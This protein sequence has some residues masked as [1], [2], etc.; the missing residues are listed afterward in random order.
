[1]NAPALIALL[2]IVAASACER[3]ERRFQELA[4]HADADGEGP[5]DDVA[6]G[7][8]EG[9]R[10][11]VWF[12]CAGCHANGGG[13]MGP[14]LMDDVWRYGSSPQAVYASIVEGRPNGMPSFGGKIPETE[15]W[16]LVAYVR[17]LSGLTRNDVVPGR[18][19]HLSPYPPPSML[20]QFRA[21]K[22]E[23]P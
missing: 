16:K 1:M 12:N 14:A 22:G 6:W 3:E 11:Y 9:A 18:N 5:Y 20:D 17:S 23:E 21:T 15:I 2:T 13:G 7:V 10:L 8:S 4:P 19:E